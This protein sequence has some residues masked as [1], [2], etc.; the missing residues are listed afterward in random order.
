MR[1]LVATVAVDASSARSL[2]VSFANPIG[3][4]NAH[5]IKVLKRFKKGML[6]MSSVGGGNHTD[7]VSPHLRN[8]PSDIRMV[9]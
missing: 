5:I 9:G 8:H 3:T 7:G 4:K 1:F 2:N 6:S